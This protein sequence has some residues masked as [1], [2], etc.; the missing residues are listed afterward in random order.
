M[1]DTRTGRVVLC[2]I[3]E[4]AL[5]E[6]TGSGI[7]NMQTMFQQCRHETEQL[8]SMKYDRWPTMAVVTERDAAKCQAAA[9]S[10]ASMT[11]NK[12]D[13]SRSGSAASQ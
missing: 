5:R 3:T 7:T 13:I 2:R 1:Q 11:S 8:A 12:D 9:P 6:L 4:E 10:L